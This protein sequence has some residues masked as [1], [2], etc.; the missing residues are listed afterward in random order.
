MLVRK[1]RAAL[2]RGA[3]LAALCWHGAAVAQ[4][5]PPVQS[6]SAEEEIVVTGIR[7]A[8][9]SAE[10]RKRDADVVVDGIT[11]DDIGL[12]P[13]VSISE[14]L[15]RISGVTA[16]DTARGSDQVAIRGLGPDLASTEYNGRILPTADG[17]NRRVGLGG[18]PSEGLRAAFVQKTPDAATIEGGVAGILSLESIRPL[19]SRRKGLT[20]VARGL[21]ESLSDSFSEASEQKPFGLRGEATYVSDFS[22]DFGI[23][24]TYAGIK[25]YNSQAG[26]QFDSWRLVSGVPAQSD[27]D[28]NGVG[29]AFPLNA[30]MIGQFFNT[31]RH[32]VLG[33]AQWRA[34][35]SLTISLD[36]LFSEETNDN[37]TRRFFALDLWNRPVLGAP[38][39][40]TVENDTVTQFE[41]TAALYRGVINDNVIEDHTY[42]AVLNFDIDDGGPLTA[43]FDFSYFEAG[44]DRFTPSVNF[45]IDATTAAGQRRNFAYDLTDRSNVTFGFGPVSA[46]DFAIQLVNT[47]KQD[48]SDEI[49]A[50]RGDFGYAVDGAFLQN[51]KF[52]ARYDHR[53]HTQRV[54][55][56]Q[57]GFANL[58]ARP[59]LDSSFL[60]TE[61]FPFAS[62]ANLFGGPSATA[63]PY[64][65]FDALFLRGSGLSAVAPDPAVPLRDT[66]DTDIAEDTFALYYQAEFDN[67]VLSGNVGVRWVQTDS[68]SR[69]FATTPDGSFVRT[70]SNS[71][72]F[73]LPSLNLKYRVAPD[74]YLRFAAART[75]SKP[76]FEDLNVGGNID[77]DPNTNQFIVNSGN[78]ELSPFTSDGI[79]AGVEWYPDRSTS[80][81]VAGYYK[82][83]SNFIT[84]NTRIGTIVLADGSIAPAQITETSNDSANRYFRGVEVQ[85]R[86]DF[87]F[88]PGLLSNLGAQANYNYNETDARETFPSLAGPAAIA[89]TV[90]V[91]PINLS[92]H[93]VNAILYYDSEPVSFR[94]AYRYY[95]SYSRRFARGYQYQ[96]GGQLDFNFGWNL[97]DNVRLIGTVTNVLGTSQYRLTEDSRNGANDKILQFYG[98]RG[99]DFALGVRVQF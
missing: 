36:G 9:S 77:F 69:G 92:T 41:G 52:G 60:E 78:P 15:T 3:C 13:D 82:W 22:D 5:A 34:S 27:F 1:S 30:G 66:P 21:Y 33:M 53:R 4:D 73:L 67:D 56:T 70:F 62:K 97:M 75:I 80:I 74:L 23:A 25:D 95:S 99:R 24:L 44:R 28:G 76:L 89:T 32:S 47:I 63:F 37:H 40:I 98:T 12:L 48:A 86:K 58:G 16:N 59:D 57:Y 35:P 96:P 61:A 90:A 91:M 93:V 51:M 11:A 50:A 19:D 7:A 83:V 8:L 42:G 54:V 45:D 6:A 71:Y 94:L 65:D 85:F 84:S 43:V 26:V 17:V 55:N 49:T 64:Y 10:G 79:D 38:T 81:A 39:S 72:D 2:A 46:D 88:L 31:E 29:D 87:D 20:I 18:L 14:S 68:K